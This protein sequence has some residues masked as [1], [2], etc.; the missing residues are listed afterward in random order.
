MLTPKRLRPL[1][2]S[3]KV[4][5]KNRIV[6]PAMASQTAD[7]LGNATQKTLEHYERL[8]KSGAG[9][10]F[11]EY[12]YVH[13]SGKSEPNQLGF[14]KD[15][16]LETLRELANV[17]HK[18]GALAGIQLTH[19]GGKSSTDLTGGPMH[20]PSGIPVPVKGTTLETP[21]SADLGIIQL[22]EDS[23][24]ASAVLAKD[25]GFDIVEL[26]AAHGYGLNQWI[27]PLTNTRE[28]KYGGDRN[29]RF[30]ILFEIVHKIKSSKSS[31][32]LS[33]RIPG[34]DFLEG[35]LDSEDCV[36]LAQDLA[37]LGVDI[38]NVSSG[39][40]G[41]RRPA[42]RTGEGYLVPEAAEIQ[43]KSSV[44]IIGVGGIES[45]DYVEEI[46]S[47][48][49]VTLVAVGRAILQNR[50]QGLFLTE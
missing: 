40:G 3:Q 29:S 37:A 7:E 4:E 11:V 10:V 25:L 22:W 15:N 13:S 45:A 1:S 34:K 23:F 8:A 38:I 12:S 43:K 2:I 9:I 42:E 6:V 41:W 28:D 36:S 27:S 47:R 16:N 19:C 49:V 39:I 21:V 17:I 46:L 44:P 5:T 26:H 20:S 18:H 35:G 24:F 32:L 48:N 50:A 33:V 30:K 31:P 14:T